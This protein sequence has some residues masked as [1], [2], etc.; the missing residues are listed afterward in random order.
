MMSVWPSGWRWSPNQPAN[1]SRRLCDARSLS[2]ARVA[3]STRELGLDLIYGIFEHRACR[4]HGLA[5]LEHSAEASALNDDAIFFA[6]TGRCCLDAWIRLLRPWNATF[7]WYRSA[8]PPNPAISFNTVVV[9]AIARSVGSLPGTLD[10]RAST[11]TSSDTLC[12]RGLHTPP[13]VGA[14]RPAEQE[15]TLRSLVPYQC[16]NSSGSCPQPVAPG[17]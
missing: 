3:P 5:G 4:N 6:D 15:T 1:D 10:R 17:R 9:I 12:A 8:T 7:V 2:L 13:Q 11:R 16:G 14:T